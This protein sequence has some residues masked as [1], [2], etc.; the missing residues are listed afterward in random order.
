MIRRPPRS[1]RTDTLFPY[2]TLFRSGCLVILAISIIVASL[3]VAELIARQQHRCAIREEHGGQ[4]GAQDAIAQ[5]LDGRVSRLAF[6]APVVAEV[7]AMPIGVLVAIGLV[8]LI[9]VADHVPGREAV[10]RSQEVDGCRS[11]EHTSDLQSPMRTSYA[12]F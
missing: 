6:L 12:V 11:E 2:T 3:A 9:V 10:V 4:H 1:T 8:M 7:L 5:S